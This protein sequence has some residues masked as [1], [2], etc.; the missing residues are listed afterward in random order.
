[1][2]FKA[3]LAIMTVRHLTAINREQR[4]EKFIQKHDPTI[5]R[6]ILESQCILYMRRCA[7]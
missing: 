6:V 4:T 1:M 2:V 3:K 5:H 7:P